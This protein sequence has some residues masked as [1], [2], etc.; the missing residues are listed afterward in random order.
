VKFAEDTAVG[1]LTYADDIW[2][3]AAELYFHPIALCL[4]VFRFLRQLEWSRNLSELDLM[5]TM[6]GGLGSVIIL[7]AGVSFARQR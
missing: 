7:L 2:G 6:L 4:L 5:G 3:T 1:V